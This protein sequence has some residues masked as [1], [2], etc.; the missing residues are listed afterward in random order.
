V[1]TRRIVVTYDVSAITCADESVL[2]A[3]ARLLLTARRM[4]VS[5]E[6]HHA[7][8]ELIDLLTLVGLAGELTLQPDGKTEEGE[9]VRVDEEVDSGDQAVRDLQSVDR[10]RVVPAVGARAPLGESRG[11]IRGNRRE[12]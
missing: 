4:G 2:E 12:A 6:L 3:L 10:P 5:I 1:P 11:A 9:Q 7:R 8:R